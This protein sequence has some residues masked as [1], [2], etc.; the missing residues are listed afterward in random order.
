MKKLSKY[1][2]LNK[3]DLIRVSPNGV[4]FLAGQQ[5]TAQEIKVLQ[6][7]IKFLEKTRFWQI[8]TNN[9]AERAKLI[10][11]EKAQS[12]DDM[13]TGKAMLYNLELIDDVKKAIKKIKV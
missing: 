1:L 7:E 4:I 13:K 11:F 12:F 9:I 6:E 3:N 10:M 8:I 2:Q 5:A